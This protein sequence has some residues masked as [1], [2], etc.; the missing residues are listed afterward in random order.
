MK[1]SDRPRAPGQR[2]PEFPG[3]TVRRAGAFS[4][5]V[6]AILGAGPLFGKDGQAFIQE[7]TGTVEV[8]APGSA[9]WTAAQKGAALR[10]GTIIS[11]GFKSTAILAAGGASIL[12]RP[13]TRLSLEE[14]VSRDN[15]ESINV[16]LRAG[17]IRAEVNPPGGGKIDFK[18]SSPEATA[19]VRG[20]AF[21]FDTLNLRVDEGQVRYEPAARSGRRGP[22]LVNAGQSSWIDPKTGAAVPPLAAAGISGGL[23]A[24]HG[25]GDPLR[26][27]G[28][29]GR[30]NISGA[31]WRLPAGT[32]S[33]AVSLQF[34]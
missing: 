17:R 22:V 27:N 30:G 29:L 31:P 23:P 15:L 3:L 19:S 1:Q 33:L 18:A 4:A 7:M 13:L 28:G 24:L 14:I 21:E 9:K 32:S 2:T 5:L 26:R 25:Q 10:T 12:I 8:M 20:T 34:Q 6:L 16:G 11:T